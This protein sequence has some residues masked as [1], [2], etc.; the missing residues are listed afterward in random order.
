[1]ARHEPKANFCIRC[2]VRLSRDGEA[3][4]CQRCAIALD[5]AYEEQLRQEKQNEKGTPDN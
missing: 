3:D 1:M 4:Y 2:G 5:D